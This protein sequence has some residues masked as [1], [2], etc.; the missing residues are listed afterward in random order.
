MLNQQTEER[1]NVW[2]R[3][4]LMIGLWVYLN[5]FFL[6]AIVVLFYTL[7]KTGLIQLVPVQVL[8]CFCL[9]VAL[10]SQHFIADHFASKL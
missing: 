9:W 10:I 4:M 3:K 5:P 7:D 2:A 8:T 6:G 1:D